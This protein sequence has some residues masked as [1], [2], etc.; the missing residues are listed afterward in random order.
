MSTASVEWSLDLGGSPR[1]VAISPNGR[2]VYV[3]NFGHNLV[4]RID[5]QNQMESGTI[6]VPGGPVGVD[7]DPS[8]MYLGVTSFTSHRVR[9]FQTMGGM[10]I[11]NEDSR[12]GNPVK[13]LFTRRT[14]ATTRVVAV[15]NFQDQGGSNGSVAFFQFTF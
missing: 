10:E 2:W 3:A 15:Q 4:H 8:G 6:P 1:D 5:A 14:T 13:V 11:A 9:I 7:V 12:G